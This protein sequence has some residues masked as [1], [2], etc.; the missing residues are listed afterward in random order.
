MA[1][2]VKVMV[3]LSAVPGRTSPLSEFRSEEN[4]VPASAVTTS[5]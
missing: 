3:V 4:P 2:A 5:I 1:A